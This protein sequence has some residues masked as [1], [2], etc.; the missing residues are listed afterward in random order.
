MP[1]FSFSHE[2]LSICHGA[3]SINVILEYV[4]L[5]YAMI[6]LN[7]LIIKTIQFVFCGSCMEI[8]QF[9]STIV[10]GIDLSGL[11][12]CSSHTCPTNTPSIY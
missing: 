4:T 10:V 2:L 11:V 3:F 7:I 8:V 1:T 9:I 12:H 5:E 6:V